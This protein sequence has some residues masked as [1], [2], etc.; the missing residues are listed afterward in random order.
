MQIFTSTPK[1]LQRGDHIWPK[2]EKQVK[3][4]G[5]LKKP[6]RMIEMIRSTEWMIWG[7]NVVLEKEQHKNLYRYNK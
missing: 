5:F 4:L 6:P 7:E 3:P 2:F 1:F